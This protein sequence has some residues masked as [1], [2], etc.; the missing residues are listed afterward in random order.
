MKYRT[1][2]DI[3]SEVLDAANGGG[4]TKTKIM[5]H[6]FLSFGQI[7]EY[8]S[9]LTENN[10]LSYDVDTQTLKTTEKGLR[11]LE[12]YNQMDDMI[13]ASPLA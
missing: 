8:L 11:F 10:L 12:A 5:Y 2:T 6:A 1:R 9:L 7:K 13:K 3:I 4:T